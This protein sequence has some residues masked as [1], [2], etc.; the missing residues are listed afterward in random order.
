M[1]E[2]DLS[3]INLLESRKIEVASV[4]KSKAAELMSAMERGY[5]QIASVL[6]P[7]VQWELTQAES[8]ADQR[9]AVVM[10][11]DAPRILRE[12]GL[13]TAKNPSGSADQRENIL[14]LDKEYQGLRNTVE[15]LDAVYELLK[16]K[17]RGFEMSYQ[18][19]KKVYDSLN[20]YGASTRLD[21]VIPDGSGAGSIIGKPQY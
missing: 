14:A 13:V 17:M 12:K 20:T 4:T 1:L 16:G 2:L 11:D 18:A 7:Q 6:I 10:L 21:N 9:K 5:S 19:V 8:V 3:E 15:M